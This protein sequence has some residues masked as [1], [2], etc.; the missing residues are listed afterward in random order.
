VSAADGA[1]P[2]R[3]AAQTLRADRSFTDPVTNATLLSSIDLEAHLGSIM[4]FELPGDC[5]P[6]F[7][8]EATHHWCF[9]SPVGTTLAFLAQRARRRAAL[10]AAE[11]A[12]A[13]DAWDLVDDLVRYKAGTECLRPL[14]EGLALFAELD[15]VP[16]SSKVTSDVMLSAA[17]C[18]LLGRSE[19]EERE[20]LVGLPLFALLHSVRCS[21]RTI[22]RKTNLLLQPLR[23]SAELSYLPGYLVARNLWLEMWRRSPRLSDTDLALLYMY[24][25]F[26][27]DYGLVA[28]L[29][30]P[31]RQDVAAVD[32]IAGY[33]VERLQSLPAADHEPNLDEL[34]RS[35]DLP[36]HSEDGEAQPPIPNLGTDPELWELGQRRFAAM[37]EELH[38]EA[39]S[40]DTPAG[41]LAQRD[42]WALAQRELLCIGRDEVTVRVRDN[43]WTTVF[44]DGV[45]IQA[46]PADDQRLAGRQGTGSLEA[47]LNPWRWGRYTVAAVS[48]DDTVVLSWFSREPSQQRLEQFRSYRL[49]LKR[50]EEENQLLDLIVTKQLEDHEDVLEVIREGLEHELDRVYGRLALGFV[51]PSIQEQRIAEMREHG[52]HSVLGRVALVRALAWTSVVSRLGLGREELARAFAE[53][54]DVHRV[55]DDFATVVAEIRR[56]GTEKLGDPLVYDS[57]NGL[58]CMI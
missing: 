41:R 21:Q 33:V 27:C 58:L 22:S 28:H 15:V 10:I 9:F 40:G 2:I 25:Y 13:I 29:L 4:Q 19:V 7:L 35:A 31:D 30:E 44:K 57:G 39:A 18:F 5:L 23:A 50:L 55:D 37:L 8:H 16:G 1:A 42:L 46:G 6:A 51:E 38:A 32:A 14:S 20:P 49:N 45:L 26:Y 36:L 34:E 47:F 48:L 53:A 3:G 43:G 24:G 52:F 11:A 54:R 56:M 17:V 12:P